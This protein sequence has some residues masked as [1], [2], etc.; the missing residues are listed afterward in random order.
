M[1][2]DAPECA[3]GFGVALNRAQE[4]LGVAFLRERSGQRQQACAADLDLATA[5]RQPA[6]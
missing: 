4:R 2:A 3:G 6:D 5:G 1:A